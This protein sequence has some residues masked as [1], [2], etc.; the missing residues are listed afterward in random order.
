MG[1]QKSLEPGGGGGDDDAG[2]AGPG[3]WPLS[4]HDR[5]L[6]HRTVGAASQLKSF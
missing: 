3:A 2:E 5:N 6:P 1:D 4:P